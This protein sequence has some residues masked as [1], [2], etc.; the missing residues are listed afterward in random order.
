[1]S[2]SV[3]WTNRLVANVGHVANCHI[4]G[5]RENVLPTVRMCNALRIYDCSYMSSHYHH[6]AVFIYAC[7]SM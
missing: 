7:G 6:Y 4:R 5:I 1:M 3:S 2:I